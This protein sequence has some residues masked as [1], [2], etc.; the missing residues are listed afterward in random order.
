MSPQL[1]SNFEDYL[2]PVTY[3]QISEIE[4]W[5]SSLYDWLPAFHRHYLMRAF[6]VCLIYIWDHILESILRCC[7]FLIQIMNKL[8]YGVSNFANTVI[9]AHGLKTHNIHIMHSFFFIR[10][11]LIRIL[12][13]KITREDGNLRIN[14]GKVEAQG[15]FKYSYKKRVYKTSNSGLYPK[16]PWVHL[17]FSRKSILSK[18]PLRNFSYDLKN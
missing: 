14:N 9:A 1:S 5:I 11:N 7:W 16:W 18:N 6:S 12:R 13:L 17:P 8:S 15:N 4:L 3:W 2:S 10:I